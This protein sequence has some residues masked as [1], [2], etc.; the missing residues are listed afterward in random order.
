VAEALSSCLRRPIDLL[1]RWGG[2]EF[3]IL[4]SDA[5]E[6]V[7]QHVA[8]RICAAVM[9]QDVAHA[10][11]SCAA[12]VTVS[13]GVTLAPAALAQEPHALL[14]AADAALYLAKRS[15]R[16]RYVMHAAAA[17]EAQPC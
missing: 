9:Q 13:I 6:A 7:A 10:A 4:L 17:S 14:Q 11:S 12:L 3:A 2:E 5:D 15:G 16:N 8:G 1:A